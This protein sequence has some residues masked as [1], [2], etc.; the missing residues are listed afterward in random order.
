MKPR[1]ISLAVFIALFLACGV[2]W[3]SRTFTHTETHST[4][5]TVGQVEAIFRAY[6]D[7]CDSDCKYS[8]PNLREIR[9]LS[10]KRNENDFYTWTWVD[11][12]IKDTTYFTHVRVQKRGDGSIHWVGEQVTDKNLIAYLKQEYGL[13]SS[14]AF[15][16]GLTTIDIRPAGTGSAITQKVELSASGFLARF[17]GRVMDGIKKSFRYTWAN[18]ER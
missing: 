12:T 8:R 6:K 2:A 1:S 5:K 13:K 4:R 18:I 17:P 10:Y 3:A 7:Y 9:L 15:D 11:S 14:P 16:T